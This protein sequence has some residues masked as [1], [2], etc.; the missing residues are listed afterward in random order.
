M[1]KKVTDGVKTPL[2]SSARTIHSGVKKSQTLV[3]RVTK[4]PIASRSALP[5]RGRSMDIA[6][7]PHITR[8][9]RPIVDKTRSVA[10]EI[11]KTREPHP[12]V[13]AFAAH[14]SPATPTAAPTSSELK[15]QLVK[16]A[17]EKTSEVNST[18][19]RERKPKNRFALTLATTFLLAVIGYA[20]YNYIPALSIRVAASQA[21]INASYPSY[22]PEGYSF[23][24][25]VSFTGGKVNIS[26][27]DPSGQAGFSI[28]ESRSSYDSSAVKQN[29]TSGWR[30]GSPMNLEEQGQ[31]IFYSLSGGRTEAAWVN[32]GILYQISGDSQLGADNIRRIVKSM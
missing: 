8:F 13:K 12:A 5:T 20:T 1:D 14:K 23:R 31:T 22:V 15:A 24:G 7:S 3:R 9:A 32:G 28:S 10:T 6:M 25:P 26:Y 18:A 30:G 16:E 17:V 11:T 29:I 2:V 21:G 19:R 27:L 4:K